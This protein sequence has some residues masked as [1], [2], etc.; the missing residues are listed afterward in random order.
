[1]TIGMP[2]ISKS[3]DSFRNNGKRRR[4][5]FTIIE[6][7]VVISVIAI[8]AALLLPALNSARLK[9][10]AVV[11]VGNQ[12]QLGQIFGM[13][14]GDNKDIVYVYGGG[15]IFDPLAYDWARA[16]YIYYDG[17]H[18]N[19]YSDL[20]MTARFWMC[21]MNPTN[22]EDFVSRHSYGMKKDAYSEA[23]ENGAFLV[24]GT[25]SGVLVTRVKQASRYFLLGD[26]VCFNYSTAS[27][28]GKG[29]YYL[30]LNSHGFHLRHSSRAN[31]LFVDGHVAALNGGNLYEMKKLAD[32]TRFPSTR[33]EDYRV[34]YY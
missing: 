24:N 27:Y 11:C 33:K 21:P 7:L 30:S 26:S 19:A 18:K 1:M 4:D 13:Y 14:S 9:G 10:K 23:W 17:R 34:S 16:Y 29:F 3:S 28:V 6:L 12:K 25:S 15:N 31:L 20:L 5:N 22:P 2:W 8:L 32:S